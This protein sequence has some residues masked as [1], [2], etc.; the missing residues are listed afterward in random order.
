MLVFVWGVGS[1]SLPAGFYQ[2]PEE[3]DTLLCDN[4]MMPNA[5]PEYWHKYTQLLKTGLAVR[6]E[7]FALS[8]A[9]IVAR[10]AHYENMISGIQLY[11]PEGE[12][13]AMNPLVLWV[14]HGTW[15]Q[16]VGDYYDPSTDAFKN[17]LQFAAEMARRKKRPV[18]VVSYVWSGVDSHT[19]RRDGGGRLRM[20]AESFFSGLCGYGP[21]WAFGHSHGVNV[22]FIASQETSFE[23]VISLGAP[24]VEALYAPLHVQQLYHFYSLN[25]P[26]QFAGAMDRSSF[27]RLVS[28][29]GVRHYSAKFGMCTVSNFRVMLDGLEPGHMSLKLLIPFMWQIMDERVARYKYHTH[30]NVN[31]SQVFSGAE[32]VVQLSIRDTIEI[33][34]L[35]AVVSEQESA[36]AVIEQLKS[37]IEY[38]Q[39]Q[40]TVF[41]WNYRGK[42]M[43]ARS[44]WWKKIVANWVELDA[45]ISDRW[46]LFKPGSYQKY[47]WLRDEQI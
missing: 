5:L 46:E 18:E 43:S 47:S 27:K 32:Q 30:F 44:A 21:H 19:A 25:D 36:A 7:W 8:D 29:P 15:A 41:M 12:V 42:K 22:I 40:D 24:V 11:Y 10:F 17:I 35:V 33:A 2:A 9:D 37:E 4:I 20:L 13:E 38:S 28:S 26:W 34:D 6:A 31:V 39:K 1:W 16:A 3:Y 23:G 14:V 45:V